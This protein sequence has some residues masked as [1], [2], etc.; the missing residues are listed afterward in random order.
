MKLF[1]NFYKSRPHPPEQMRRQSD[2]MKPNII[3]EHNI[4]LYEILREHTITL[5]P[6][7]DD[8]LPLLYKWNKDPEVLYWNEGPDANPNNNN[9]EAV[10]SIYRETSNAGYCFIIEIDGKAI[11]ECLLCKMTLQYIIEKYPASTDIRRIDILIG[12]K[13]YW[14]MGIGST[15]VQMLVNLAFNNEKTDII[16]GITSDYNKRSGR[17]FQKNGFHLFSTYPTDN[18]PT[19]NDPANKDPANKDPAKNNLELHYRLTREEYENC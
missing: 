17:V 13:S 4:T 3:K 9:D 7:S 11:G 18:D 10:Q 1:L 19:S 12:E 8:H 16:Y 15:I 14:N 2:Y 6:L 5:R